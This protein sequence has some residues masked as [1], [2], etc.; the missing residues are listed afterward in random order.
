MG[1]NAKLWEY[2]LLEG[3][4]INLVLIHDEIPQLFHHFYVSLNT[5]FHMTETANK[6]IITNWDHNAVHIYGD[7][8][9]KTWAKA[10]HPAIASFD[11]FRINIA[12]SAPKILSS[13]IPSDPLI[14]NTCSVAIWD[15]ALQV[16]DGPQPF[17]F[18][19]D[20]V[21]SSDICIE[22][23]TRQ[24][25]RPKA[26]WSIRIDCDCEINYAA[27]ILTA[28]LKSNQLKSQDGLLP[29]LWSIVVGYASKS[30]IPIP[31]PLVD[32]RRYR[33]GYLAG[34]AEWYFMSS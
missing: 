32:S 2:N 11:D 24:I 17:H 7:V 31:I 14:L 3:D 8:Y 34:F 27:E 5:A 1:P 26:L 6:H 13:L 15:D 19:Y 33:T 25:L 4:L 28:L 23:P 21:K 16:W 22:N 9:A 30:K 10:E 12:T 18:V 20:P 29:E